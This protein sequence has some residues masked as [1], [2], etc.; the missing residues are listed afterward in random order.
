MQRVKPCVATALAAV[1]ALVTALPAQ[2]APT[3]IAYDALG[4]SF[5]AGTGAGTPLDMCARTAAAHPQLLSGR[6]Q[7]Q[8]DDLAACA[9][10]DLADIAGQLTALD[11]DTALVSISIGGNE[12]DWITGVQL[13][14]SGIPGLCDGVVQAG[15][16][17][18]AA[19]TAPLAQLFA[20]VRLHAPNAQ[21]VVTGYPRFFSP[22]Y[23]DF[24]GTYQGVPFTLTTAS[25]AGLNSVTDALNASLA[26]AAAA[27]G[28]DFVGVA[29]RFVDHGVNAPSPWITGA[30][31]MAPLHPT[32]QGQRAYAAAITAAVT[33]ASLR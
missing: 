7:L 32:S 33:P 25:Q 3:P 29:D 19:L 12:L 31:S 30:D 16:A 21:V 23:G 13:C 5:A 14:A 26:T 11:A 18:A 10:A 17:G 15:Q 4:D 24:S 22:E 2:A 1:L 6:M 28:V 27:A 9:G 8:L 20:A